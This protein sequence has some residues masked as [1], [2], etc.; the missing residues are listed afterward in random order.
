MIA[1]YLG[2]EQTFGNCQIA[3][4]FFVAGVFLLVREVAHDLLASTG[5]CQ[6]QAVLT[7][8]LREEVEQSYG[9]GQLLM[10]V[11]NE[12][13]H[14]VED[15]LQLLEGKVDGEVLFLSSQEAAELL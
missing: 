8:K 7:I 11:L 9:A 4:Q 13:D 15:F 14:H 12:F 5:Q 2:Q 3:A 6:F 10:V 1:L